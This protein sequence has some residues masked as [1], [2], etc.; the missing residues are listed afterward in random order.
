MAACIYRFGVARM[1][2]GAAINGGAPRTAGVLG[3]VGS[4]TNTPEFTDH[5]P[6]EVLPV[7]GERGGVIDLFIRVEAHKLAKQKVVVNLL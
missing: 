6:E 2:S 5:S 1:A 4:N 3:H 7:F